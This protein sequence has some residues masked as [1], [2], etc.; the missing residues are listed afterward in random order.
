MSRGGG[1]GTH[2]RIYQEEEGSAPRTGRGSHA[3]GYVFSSPLFSDGPSGGF[4]MLLMTEEKKQEK[5][6]IISQ[7]T[8]EGK[9]PSRQR[10]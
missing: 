6:T 8:T 2:V 4:G 1:K 5:K 10:V 7:G 3:K 9:M